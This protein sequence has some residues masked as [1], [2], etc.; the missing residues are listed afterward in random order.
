MNRFSQFIRLLRADFKRVTKYIPSM[1]ISVSILFVVCACAGYV[2]SKNLYKENS[3]SAV[4]VAYYMAES[5]DADM[6]LLSVEMLQEVDSVKNT[7][8]I[9]RVDS[10]EEGYNMLENGDILFFIVI[11]E[12]FFNGIVDGTNTPLDIIVRDTS[13]VSSYITNEVFLSYAAYL[14]IAQSCIYSVLD[15]TRANDF[16]ADEIHDL[17]IRVN[18]TFIDRMNKD[19]YMDVVDATDEGK[20]TLLQHYLASALMLVL[21]LL[22]VVLMPFIQ[23]HSGGITKLLKLRKINN[24][25]IFLSNLICSIPAFYL[26]FI[27]CYIGI[28]IYNKSLFAPGLLTVL[29]SIC[30]ITI[31]VNLVGLISRHIFTGNMILFCITLILAYIGGGLLPHAFLPSAIQ[32]ISRVLPGEY[33][34]AGFAHALF[35]I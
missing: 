23:G 22:S 1:L 8:S 33:L 34:I 31:I 15:V 18:L 2:I 28:S 11:P 10:I 13:S 26:A 17:D 21:L 32:A 27:P 20:G 14:S 3:F 35:G 4:N 19:S 30:T 29:P 9:F 12:Q 5:E 6:T 24:I 7:A 16:P 25:H